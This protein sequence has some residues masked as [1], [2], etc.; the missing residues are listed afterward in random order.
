MS[1]STSVAD[2]SSNK[3][4]QLVHAAEVIGRSDHRARVFREVY[5]GKVRT[6]SVTQL[7]AATGLPRTRVLDAGKSL[8]GNDIIV[9]VKADGETAYAK[10]DFFQ[11]YRD[12]IL[13]LAKDGRRRDA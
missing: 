7:M 6:K 1:M 8:A 11:P 5:R 4:E 3:N 12:R 2:R 9:A 10:I 13:K